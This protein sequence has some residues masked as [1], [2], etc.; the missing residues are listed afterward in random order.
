M[1]QKG[2]ASELGTQPIGK[3]LT[4]YA[5]PAIIAMT[6]SSLYNM[7]DSIFIGHGVGAMAI[8]GLAITFPLMNLAAAF[9]SLVGVGAS[10]LVSVK[11]GQKDYTTAQHILGNVV[12]LNV[13]IGIGFTILSLLFLDPIL[14]F[15]G[16]SEATIPYARDYMIVI[17]LGNVVTHMYLGL[18][19]VLRAAGYP[20]KAMFATIMT[21]V[22]N[23]IL[24]PIFI[25]VFHWGIQG[26]ALAT[27]LA[28][29]IALTWQIKLFCRKNELLRLKKGIYRLQNHLVQNIIGIGL[30]PFFMNIAACMIVILINKGLKLYDG[31]LAI[32]AFGIVNRISFLFVMIVM[33]LNQGMQPIAGYNYGARQYGRVNQVMKITVIAATIVTTTG[34]LVGELIPELVA[35]AFTTDQTLI[36]LSARGLRIT[37]MFFPIIGFQMVTSNFFQS[38]G[39]AKK[40][41]ILSLSRQVMILIPL[42]LILPLFW[43]A[44][45]IW[46]SMPIS[47]L[48]ASIIAAIMLYRQFKL[49]KQKAIA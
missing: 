19:S 22:I 36:D 32:G 11:L 28:Q 39:M 27:V 45:G 3:L 21:V 33:G 40:A 26:V 35:K 46:F 23:T 2:T 14:Y 13:L 38:I 49:F 16:A 5:V 30:A 37:V 42:L 31:D 8:S 29:I 48:A 43:G 10:T 24:A 6:A 15:F 17:L 1:S 12:S 44:D 18:N 34:F 4:Q 41:I 7:I 9:G 25:F 20:Q 47:D